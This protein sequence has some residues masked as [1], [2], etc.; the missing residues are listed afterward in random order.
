[1]RL[2]NP[3]AFQHPPQPSEVFH[4][5]SFSDSCGD[6]KQ[7]DR[8]SKK[9]LGEG[10]ERLSRICEP[11]SICFRPISWVRA[12]SSASIGQG[13]RLYRHFATGYDY[14]YQFR[15]Y[16]FYFASNFVSV[17]YGKVVIEQHRIAPA[18]CHKSESLLRRRCHENRVSGP[19]Q[20]RFFVTQH[21]LITI[22]AQN[23][24]FRGGTSRDH[25]G[26][27]AYFRPNSQAHYLTRKPD[28]MHLQL[29][30]ISQNVRFSA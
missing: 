11:K 6:G 12:H 19:L 15:E 25:I 13:Q 7:D 3:A 18:H 8:Y 21:R 30:A 9:P 23:D 20:K 14:D 28:A 27:P 26:P 17:Y 10:E 29:S 1:M 2:F 5:E 16:A 24:S 22:D 4:Q